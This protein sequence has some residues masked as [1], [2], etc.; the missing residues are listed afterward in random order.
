VARDAPIIADQLALGD[1]TVGKEQLF[2]MRD[3]YLMAF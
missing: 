2:G 3:F 1:A